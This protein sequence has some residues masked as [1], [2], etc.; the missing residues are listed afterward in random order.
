[1]VRYKN[2]NLNVNEEFVMFL[3][4]KLI[5]CFIDGFTSIMKSQ[6]I[7][8]LVI[9]SVLNMGY[10]DKRPSRMQGQWFFRSWAGRVAVFDWVQK[11]SKKTMGGCPILYM[12][13]LQVCR[14]YFNVC[15]SSRQHAMYVKQ[16]DFSY[17]KK[18]NTCLIGSWHDFD[19]IS[20]R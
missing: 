1:M 10:V 13:S 19:L 5:T 9:G 18:K 2:Y 16:W 11:I 15:P 20:T 6:S 7:A 14:G 17:Q 4:S 8:Y 3:T 12:L